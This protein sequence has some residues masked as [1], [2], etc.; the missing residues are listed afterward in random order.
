VL[1]KLH[2]QMRKLEDEIVTLRKKDDDGKPVRKAISFPRGEELMEFRSP[3]PTVAVSPSPDTTPLSPASLLVE[4]NDDP[5]PD[6]RSTNSSPNVHGPTGRTTRSTSV[7]TLLPT[8]QPTAWK[9]VSGPVSGLSLQPPLTRGTVSTLSATGLHATRGPLVGFRGRSSSPRPDAIYGLRSTSPTGIRSPRP[10][11][12]V[13]PR[14]LSPRLTQA[15]VVVVPS[16][17]PA[18]QQSP[19]VQ[20][21]APGAQARQPSPPPIVARSPFASE[22]VRT[23][24]A[25]PIPF[26]QSVLRR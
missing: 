25:A 17:A 5:N 6:E 16:G 14:P 3:S 21:I 8:P 23:M 22:M 11:V 26:L 12:L 24:R 7:A 19:V 10:P 1:E 9:P 2:G 4:K 20:V 18:R 13:S 15:P